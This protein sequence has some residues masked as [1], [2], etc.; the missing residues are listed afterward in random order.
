MF[1]NWVLIMFAQHCEFT[2]KKKKNHCIVHFKWVNLWYVHYSSIKLVFRKVKPVCH[3]IAGPSDPGAG[4]PADRVGWRAEVTVE[5]AEV[6]EF[7]QGKERSR[8]SLGRP[9]LRAAGWCAWAQHCDLR[10]GN[11]KPAD[12]QIY[13]C[14]QQAHTR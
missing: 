2:K 9:C 5:A 6:N 11:S 14:V 8:S 7:T 12:T 3:V 10:P 4:G 13:Q 1:Y